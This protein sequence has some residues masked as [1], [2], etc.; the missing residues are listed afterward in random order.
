MT[1]AGGLVF[2]AAT[3]DSRLR[4]F[5]SKTGRML[6]EQTIDANGHTIPITYLGKDG[7]Q[8][9][10]P[11]AQNGGGY[12]GGTPS[13]AVVA[14]ALGAEPA[15]KPVPGISSAENAKPAVRAKAPV[16]LPEGRGKQVLQRTC[17]RACHTIDVV[18]GT[19][20]DRAAWA[21]MVDDMVARG[22]AAKEDDIKLIIDYLVTHFGK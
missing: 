17:G 5:E 3:N 9:V 6:W 19:R 16:T 11:T 21:A 7:K 18:T 2:I 1:T 10:A 12:F 15:P 8:Y 14:F 22:A 13:D 20:R 4:A